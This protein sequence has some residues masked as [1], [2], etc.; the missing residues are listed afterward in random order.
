M[1]VEINIIPMLPENKCIDITVD[2]W[3]TFIQI[4]G[5]HPDDKPDFRHHLH[6]IQ[7]ILYAH[8]YKTEVPNNRMLKQ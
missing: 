8:K 2:L 1:E 4:Q 5:L 7:N 6:A 3:N